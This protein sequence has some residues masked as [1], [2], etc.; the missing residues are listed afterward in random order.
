MDEI[1]FS[2]AENN[3]NDLVA[4][5]QQY[6]EALDDDGDMYESDFETEN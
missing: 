3:M 6:Q 4:E 2:E 5:Y 1:E